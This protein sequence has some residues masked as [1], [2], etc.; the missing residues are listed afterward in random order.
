V[1]SPSQPQARPRPATRRHESARTRALDR[2]TPPSRYRPELHGVRGLSILGVVLFHIFGDGRVSGGIDIFLAV[3]GFLFTAMLLRE[4]ARRGG[5]IDLGRY[6]AR[7]FRRILPPAALVAVV[8]ALVGYLVLPAT[9]HHQI[10][11]EARASLLYFE[12]LELISSQLVYEAAGPQSSPFQHFWSLSV[13]GQFYVLW[14]ALTVVAVLVAR[15]LRR[16]AVHLMAAGVLVVLAGSLAWALHMHATNQAEAYLMTTTRLWQLAFGGVLAVL[17]SRLTL[18]VAWRP[19]AGWLG[20]AL[21]ASCGF[22]LDGAELFPGLWSLWPLLGLTLVLSSAGPEGGQADP[23]GSVTRVL[24]GRPLAVVGDHAYALYLWHWPVLIFV[25]DAASADEVGAGTGALVLAVSGALAWATRRWIEQPIA[26]APA[27][28]PR[29]PLVLGAGALLAGGVALSLAATATQ[30]EAPEGWSTAGVD[31]EVFPGAAATAGDGSAPPPP[32]DLP[33]SDEAA[34]QAEVDDAGF[35]PSSALLAADQP[36]YYSWDCR[37]PLTETDMSTA[38]VL[39]CEDPD[40]PAD[41]AH[42]VMLAGG[43]HAG[44][45]QHAWRLLAEE[46]GWELLIADKSGCLLQSTEE[47]AHNACAAWNVNLIDVIAE[48]QPDLVVTPGT[49][50]DRSHEYVPSGAP[51]RWQRIVEAGSSVLLVRGTPR[52]SQDAADCLA[53]SGDVVQCGADARQITAQDPLRSIDLPAGVHTVD[54]TEHICP[55]VSD[56]GTCPAVVGNVAVWRDRSHLST[57]YTETLAPQL[58]ARVLEAVPQLDR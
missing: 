36:A 15:R 13:Q 8:T 12:N 41:P 32:A 10:F 22:V 47:A 14:P 42:T 53:E 16:P 48:R 56:A 28:S 44:Q 3:S 7:L 1:R 54:L 24:S 19:A 30:V 40:P 20:L 5:R 29:P 4:A 27:T 57:Y 51:E 23:P 21:I 46:H 37:Q 58:G 55:E 33:P 35:L 34:G 2:G 45:W 17:G 25:L 26:R 52:P 9:Q 6:F 11:A 50:M 18:P 49:V 43:S 38:E 31:A 39:V